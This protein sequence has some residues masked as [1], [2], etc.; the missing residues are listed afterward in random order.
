MA[1]TPGWS[2][3]EKVNVRG[4]IT[5]STLYI[6][7]PSKAAVDSAPQ[8]AYPFA[9][10][11]QNGAIKREGAVPLPDLADIVARSQRVVLVLAACDVT[12]LR[13]KVPP[14]SAAKLKAALPNLV[15]DQLL[16]DPAGCVVAAGG[17]SDGLRTAAVVQRAWLDLLAKTFFSFGARQMAALPAQLCLPY[18]SGE[19]NSAVA[20]VSEQGAGIDLTLRLS[21]LEGVGLA[22][23]VAQDETA[24]H[25]AIRNLCTVAHR[26]PISLYV[27]QSAVQAYQDAVNNTG[28]PDMR[29]NVI[30]D[31]WP[32]WIAGANGTTLDF[33]AWRG[34]RSGSRQWRAWRSSVALAA[35][36]LVINIAALNIDWWRMKSEAKSLH[37]SM[38][39]IYKA[40]YP[41]EPVIIDPV[42]QMQQKIAIGKRNSGLAAPDDFMA[43]A[44]AFGEAWA[45]I[46]LAAGKTVPAI[47][48]LEY[49][50][51]G[52]FVRLKPVLSKVE[53]P[54]LGQSEG[55]NGEAPMQQMKAALAVHN[56]LLDLAAE[57]SAG[58][59][60]HI[61]SAK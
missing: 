4:E 58:V 13:V 7:L 10:V 38:V 11:L 40:A 60:W 50:E 37:T 29:V 21:E 18:Q 5:L 31:N 19:Q 17:V 52:L 57:Q 61:R 54:V 15:E 24:A 28:S 55:S 3:F 35:A 23:N 9:L 2:G 6:R 14:L 51:H 26:V 34:V 33:M 39:Q 59:V 32:L 27:P 49:R 43:I 41:N 20:A 45:S 47:A 36:I 8:V 48:A 30:A 42:A 56:L 22:I 53:G 1:P 46:A 44:A 25:E 16:S 12:M